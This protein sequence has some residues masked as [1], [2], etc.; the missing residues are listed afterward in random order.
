MYASTLTY[1]CNR[2]LL[3]IRYTDPDF[4]GIDWLPN[5]WYLACGDNVQNIDGNV[6]LREK[7]TG[8]EYVG[9][10][11]PRTSDFT[12]TFGFGF[13]FSVR[14]NVGLD[15]GFGRF[16]RFDKPTSAP[17]GTKLG[18]WQTYAIR[19]GVTIGFPVETKE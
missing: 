11:L 1:S 12:V 16:L 6:K 9:E 19:A 4:F 3:G 8:D 7:T 17:D 13:L 2:Y 5:Y 15:M 14:P 18:M 10:L